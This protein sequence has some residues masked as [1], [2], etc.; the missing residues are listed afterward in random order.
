MEVACPTAADRTLYFTHDHVDVPGKE[1]VHVDLK[2][3][4]CLFFNGSLVH[5]SSPNSSK[6]RFRRALIFHYLPQSSDELSAGYANPRQFDGTR[7][8]VA[9]ATGGGPCGGD[10]MALPMSPH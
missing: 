9:P 8:M 3:G 2:A 7:V 10:V 6:D 4:D 1:P 5:G